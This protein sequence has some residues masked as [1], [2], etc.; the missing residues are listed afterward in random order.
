M[1]YHLSCFLLIPLLSFSL[2]AQQMPE[3][4]S[5]QSANGQPAAAAPADDENMLDDGTPVKLRLTNEISSA[6]AKAG[7]QISFAAVDDI[8]LNGITVLHRGSSVSG[9]I[10]EADAKKRMGRGG[11][12]NFTIG[13]LIL[14]DGEKVNLRAVRESSGSSHV[15]GMVELMVNMPIAA[16]PFFLLMHGE[17][18]SFPKGT[19]ITAFIDGDKHLD[20]SK[21]PGGSPVAVT[22]APLAGAPSTDPAQALAS[23]TIE[24]NPAGAEIEIDGAFVGS[25]PSTI[26]AAQGSHQIALKKKGFN[27]WVRTISVTEGNIHVN[28]DLEQ[29]STP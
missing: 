21:F 28:A 3:T 7:D 1:R 29:A 23:I 20:L 16:A 27:N 15:A 25:T 24:S 17:D 10:T 8:E 9:V 22:A 18:A 12:L 4:Q 11:K 6:T 2:V 5:P 13:N 19:V 26:G 14:A